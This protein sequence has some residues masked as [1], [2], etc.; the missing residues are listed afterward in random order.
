MKAGAR[1]LGIAESYGP[2]AEPDPDRSVLAG[3]V[4][5]TDRIVDGFVFDTITVGGTDATP[6][7]VDCWSRLDRPDVETVL[8][9]GIALA[10]FNPVDLHRVHEA[11]DRPVAAVTFEAS[12][13]LESAI[14]DA[15]EGDAL[16]ERLAVYRRQPNRERIALNE[17]TVYVRGVGFDR[18]GTAADVVRAVTPEGG[19]PE[20]VRVAR[21]AARAGRHLLT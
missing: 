9:A 1:T 13:G 20:P 21:L 3:I 14:E 16:S 7:L 17:T 19:R 2:P 15:F 5:R 6:T 8:I 18:S 11:T 12:E 10:W 4:S